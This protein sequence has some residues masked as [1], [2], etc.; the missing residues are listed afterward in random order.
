[1]TETPEPCSRRYIKKS[2]MV[3]AVLETVLASL[4]FATFTGAAIVYRDPVLG[5][6]AG[7]SFCGTLTTVL[8]W[9]SR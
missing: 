2:R 6:L 5:F 3:E 7:F 4:L 1:M 8:Y 9:C